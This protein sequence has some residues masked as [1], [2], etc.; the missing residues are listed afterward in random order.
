MINHQTTAPRE[1]SLQGKVALI[2]GG[3]AGIGLAIAERYL[4]NGA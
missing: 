2:T 3:A 4:Q 1:L